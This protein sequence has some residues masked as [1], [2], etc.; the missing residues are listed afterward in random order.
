MFLIREE[1]PGTKK[2]DTGT[3]RI[4]GRVLGRN[5]ETSFQSCHPQN[6]RSPVPQKT[7]LNPYILLPTHPP[8]VKRNDVDRWWYHLQ[9]LPDYSHKL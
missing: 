9:S 5:N 2:D 6:P 1:D 7:Q 3:N 8:S 4:E